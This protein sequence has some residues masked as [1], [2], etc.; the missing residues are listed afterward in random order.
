MVI[1]PRRRTASETHETRAGAHY[2]MPVRPRSSSASLGIGCIRN[3]ALSADSGQP[4]KADPWVTPTL[5]SHG[6]TGVLDMNRLDCRL[7]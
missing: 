6:L 3:T 1:S 7:V 5:L 4:A 2:P